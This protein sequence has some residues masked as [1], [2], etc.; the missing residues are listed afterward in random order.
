MACLQLWPVIY[1]GSLALI[2]RCLPGLSCVGKVFLK[3]L[4]NLILIFLSP[5]N[6]TSSGNLEV[7]S[8]ASTYHFHCCQMDVLSYKYMSTDKAFHGKTGVGLPSTCGQYLDNQQWSSQKVLPHLKL[9]IKF[10][11]LISV[12]ELWWISSLNLA[13]MMPSAWFRLDADQVQQDLL[14][15][16]FDRCLHEWPIDFWVIFFF[17]EIFC[18]S[19]YSSMRNYL[20]VQFYNGLP[21]IIACLD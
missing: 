15:T 19:E 21:Y 4:G 16:P 17:W 10:C 11:P 20:V 9:L 6:W 18:S 12:W 7:I 5:S 14:F 8:H 13:W 3:Y 1:L 2:W